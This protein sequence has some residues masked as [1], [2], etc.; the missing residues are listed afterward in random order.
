MFSKLFTTAAVALAASGLVS[1]QTHS[2]CNPVKGDKCPDDKALAASTEVDF[3]KGA[4]NVF[5]LAA[6][7]TLTYGADGAVFTIA[8]EGNAPTITSKNYIFFGKVDV[9][10]KASFGTGIVTSFVLQS[11]DL[12]EIDWE[13][14]GGDTAQVQT[15]Y[16]SKG[17]DSTYDR[18]GFSPVSNP[19]T[20][21]HKYTIDWTNSSLTWLIDDNV[22]RVLTYNDAKGG[23]TYPQTPMQI[24]LGTW[25]G[26]SSTAQQGTIDWAGGLTDFSQA[27]FI[28][29]YKKLNIVNYSNG[30]SGATAYAYGDSSGTMGSIIVKTDG[31]SDDGDDSS[32]SSSS[33]SHSTKSSTSKS[34][35]KTSS[36][37]V[38]P[39]A[40]SNATA[41]ATESGPTG[42]GASQTSSG[43]TTAPTNA[44][45]NLALT[46][47]NSVAMGAA[48][49]LASLL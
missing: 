48:M 33:S 39:T 6:G 41:T 34:A 22:V 25:V 8:K 27:P 42:T 43:P 14:L 45:G 12:D 37:S 2:D 11:D 49:F 21:W 24:K 23:T 9:W 16:F 20:E 26:G 10:C 18:G 46:L 31:S 15:N 40:S 29:Y 30:H 28:G 1:A 36:S 19:Q 32:S 7:T 17:D 5:K 47:G 38:A 35:S 13:W 44:A 4:S 3:T